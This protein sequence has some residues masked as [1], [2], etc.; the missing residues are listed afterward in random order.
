MAHDI[1]AL[2]GSIRELEL[3]L[4]ALTDGDWLKELINLIHKPPFTTLP[5]FRLVVAAVESMTAQLGGII[6]LRDDLLQA[7]REIKESE[8]A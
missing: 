5:E 3:G 1:D 4:S 6:S 7:S 8:S 2:D